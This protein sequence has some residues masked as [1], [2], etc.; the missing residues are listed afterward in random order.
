M[1]NKKFIEKMKESLISERDILV[2]QNFKEVGVDI[3]GDE[4]D[5]IQGNMLFN[6]STQICI[7]NNAKIKKIDEA[8]L[9]IEDNTYGLCEDCEEEIAEKRL[10]V[11]PYFTT[12]VF[13][14][15]IR[16]KEEG[17]RKRALS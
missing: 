4:T 6:I 3:D 17:Q 8:L 5:E 13:C 10:L 7:R 9:K 12:C 11:N 1:L 16:E 2:S 14:S 15:E